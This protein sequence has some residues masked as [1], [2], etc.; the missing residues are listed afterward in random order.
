MVSIRRRIWEKIRRRRKLLVWMAILILLPLALLGSFGY[1][2]LC[3]KNELPPYALVQQAYLW[4]QERPLLRRV[5][6][7]FRERVTETQYGLG[8]F[9]EARHLP[10]ADSLDDHQREA[11]DKLLSLGYLTATEEAPDWENVTRYVPGR[12]YEGLNLYTSGHGPEAVLIDMK[13]RVLHRWRCTFRQAFPGREVPKSAETLDYWRRAHLYENGDLL[14]IFEGFGLIKLDKDSNLIWANPRRFHHDMCVGDQ[15]FIYTLSREAKIRPEIHA[16][17]PVLEDFVTILDAEGNVLRNV[18][19]LE[20]FARSSYASILY[21][22]PDEGDLFHTNTLEL[23]DGTQAKR[24]PIFRRGNVLI[25]M[26][27]FSTIAIVDLKREEVVWALTGQWLAQHQPTLLDNAHILLLD[28][29]GHHGMSKVIEIDALTQEIAWAYH[30]TPQN[31]FFTA[32]CGS[33]QRL[34]NG[35]T[36]ITESDAGRAFELTRRQEIVWEYFNPARAGDNEELIATLFELVR[37]PADFPTDWL[38]PSEG[39]S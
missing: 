27:T 4:A 26:R 14:A 30:G 18:S 32:S 21:N 39:E 3:E 31:G 1:G 38:E 15:G 10:G 5:Y 8:R 6:G 17:E 24:S 13:G 34:P 23:L 22:M 35:N 16:Y 29:L 25:S 37:L 11:M 12:A 19:L 28:N 9:H 20:A 33:S 2:V 36:L 7:V